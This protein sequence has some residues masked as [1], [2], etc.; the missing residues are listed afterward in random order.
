MVQMSQG[1][2]SLI[3]ATK[4]WKITVKEYVSVNKFT[5]L[6]FGIKAKL[7]IQKSI[8]LSLG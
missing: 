7:I 3:V 4:R 5:C 8:A 2:K 6:R 1:I